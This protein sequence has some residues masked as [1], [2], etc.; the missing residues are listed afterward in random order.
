MYTNRRKNYA[1]QY[2][3]FQEAV[4]K[5]ID[6]LRGGIKVPFVIGV[7]G[8]Y[9]TGKTFTSAVK[10][11]LWKAQTDAQI[12]SNYRLRDA[13]LFEHYEDWFRVAH[14]HGTIIVFDESQKDW[15]AR[16]FSGSSQ[17]DKTHIMNYVRKMNSIFMFV[18]PDFSDVDARVRKM[19][20][21]LIHLERSRDG[22][23]ITKVFDYTD[24]RFGDHGRLI[25]K[26]YLSFE[27]QKT[28]FKLN[29]YNTNQM[30]LSFPMPPQT[31]VD[32]FFKQLD[33]I[34]SAAVKREYP[35]RKD[36]Q[37]MTKDDLEIDYIYNPNHFEEVMEDAT[38]QDKKS[39]S[40]FIPSVKDSKKPREKSE[41]S[42]EFIL[43]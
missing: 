4:Y 32:T 1:D 33:D 37:I 29:L 35:E 7:E 3:S 8:G 42:S 28:I 40:V 10:S 26:E 12:F 39:K 38:K 23:I 17:V 31:E 19:C 27:K 18:L 22:T 43:V 15:D 24:K 41:R 20:E 11:H 16:R 25:K 34:H 36:I 9:G 14:M 5:I 30:V 2:K 6:R 21:I 13:F